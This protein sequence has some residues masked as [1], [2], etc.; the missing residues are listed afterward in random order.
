MTSRESSP[1]IPGWT[2]VA[3]RKDAQG[4]T[5]LSSSSMGGRKMPPTG[6]TALGSLEELHYPYPQLLASSQDL[7]PNRTASGQAS[8]WAGSHWANKFW[9]ASGY[10]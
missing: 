3:M 10:G 1:E 7:T 2:G 8:R 6:C 4:L 5:W 9:A